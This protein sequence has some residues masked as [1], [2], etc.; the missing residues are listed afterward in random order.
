M[1]FFAVAAF[2]FWVF[3]LGR[4]CEPVYRLVYML[5]FGDYLRAP[6]K[7]HHLTEF[8]LCVLAGFGIAALGRWLEAGAKG[9]TRLTLA[10]RCAIAAL[11]LW[12]VI[13]LAGEARRFCAPVDYSKAIQKG[14]SSQLTVLTRQQF[15]DPQVAEMVRRGLVVSV[16]NWLG[17]P[18]AYLVQVLQPLE[19]PKSAEPKSLP[20]TL[21]V[22]SVLAVVVVTFIVFL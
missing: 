7:W 11:V 16:A 12:G 19:P 18:D 10:F 13:D 2:V 3:S 8:C 1:L 9:S 4:N 22:V 14:C 5:P 17:S 15:Q 21:G 20:L 6:V